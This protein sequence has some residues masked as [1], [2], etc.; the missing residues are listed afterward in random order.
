M[1]YSPEL[2]SQPPVADKFW[3][4]LISSC[5]PLPANS[6]DSIV[7]GELLATMGLLGVETG[8]DGLILW[9][10]RTTPL[11]G[12]RT[13]PP[14]LLLITSQSGLFLSNRNVMRTLLGVVRSWVNSIRLTPCLLMAKFFCVSSGDRVALAISINMVVRSRLRLALIWGLPPLVR[15]KNPSPVVCTLWIW[16]VPSVILAAVENSGWVGELWESMV[17]KLYVLL[18]A[19]GGSSSISGLGS[20]TVQRRGLMPTNLTSWGLRV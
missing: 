9:G 12:N 11:V 19:V 13:K 1:R 3:S 15:I 6:T 7:A 14:A 16:V 18:L 17:A 10:K 20:C 5:V 4:A 8:V 2:L